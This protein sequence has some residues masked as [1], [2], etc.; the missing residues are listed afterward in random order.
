MNH[1]RWV[2]KPSGG[3]KEGIASLEI[4]ALL[5]IIIHSDHRRFICIITFRLMITAINS[6]YFFCVSYYYGF[7]DDICKGLYTKNVMENSPE[8]LLFTLLKLL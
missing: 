5:I 8:K 6:Y 3:S 2:H 1:L 7:T 4:S